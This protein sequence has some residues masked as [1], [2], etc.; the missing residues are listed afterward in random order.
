MKKEP[1]AKKNSGS[2]TQASAGKDSA[3]KERQP[4]ETFEPF[5]TS[6]SHKGKRRCQRYTSSGKQC[7]HIALTGYDCCAQRHSA[8]KGG[9]PPVNGHR[10]K[11]LRTGLLAKY[12]EIQDNEELVK[13]RDNIRLHEAL[14]CETLERLQSQSY[15]AELWK[16]ASQLFDQAKQGGEK[17]A[18]AFRALGKVL[19]NGKGVAK[20]EDRLLELMDQQRRHRES[21]NRRVAQNEMNLNLREANAL[22]AALKSAIEAE[23]PDVEQRKRISLRLI[24]ILRPQAG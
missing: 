18:E 8:G 22:V 9:R 1:K 7:G 12:E 23:V 15:P 14:I 5:I 3:P 17:G 11:F 13:N 19:K 10:S 2:N 4:R 6:G 16:E 24:R 21:E 20:D